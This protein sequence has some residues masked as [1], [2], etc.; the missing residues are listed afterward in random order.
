MQQVAKFLTLTM[1]ICAMLCCGC[2]NTGNAQSVAIW[3]TT[4]AG[5]MDA[6]FFVSF[7]EEKDYKNLGVDI[8]IKSDLDNCSLQIKKEL[9][10]F[11][12]IS[13]P[14][15]NTYYSLG[16][17]MASAKNENFEYKIYKD[18]VSKAYIINSEQEYNLTIK[19]VVGEISTYKTMLLS[20]FD[21]SKEFNIIVKAKENK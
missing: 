21:V 10:S 17:L 5:S 7:M 9:E 6:T 4:S 1:I 19:A 3:E 12:T 15:K 2:N 8:W 11:V 13:L 18:A 16:K 20:A 14:Q